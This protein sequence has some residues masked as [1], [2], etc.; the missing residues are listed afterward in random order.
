MIKLTKKQFARV[1]LLIV[2]GLR[3]LEAPDLI[4]PSLD[5]VA[6][7]RKDFFEIAT[8]LGIVIDCKQ[9]NTYS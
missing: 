6:Q 7:A 2:D 5:G 3:S 8:H 4:S 1:R 9:S